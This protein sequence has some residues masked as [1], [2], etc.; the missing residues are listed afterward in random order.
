MFS[1]DLEEVIKEPS[2]YFIGPMRRAVL[3]VRIDIEVMWQIIQVIAF[4]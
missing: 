1:L 3:G 4:A 2:I